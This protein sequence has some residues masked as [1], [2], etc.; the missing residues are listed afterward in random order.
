MVV[1]EL[2]KLIGCDQPEDQDLRYR[3]LS[4]QSFSEQEIYTENRIMNWITQYV[5]KDEYYP[6]GA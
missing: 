4:N 3:Q 2:N 6:P 5:D 1:L